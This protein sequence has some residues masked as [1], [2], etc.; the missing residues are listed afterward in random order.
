MPS[1]RSRIRRAPR[2][3][4]EVIGRTERVR[5]VIRIVMVAFLALRLARAIRRLPK[6]VAIVRTPATTPTTA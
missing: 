1:L 5:A 6:D 2:E 4:P 3:E